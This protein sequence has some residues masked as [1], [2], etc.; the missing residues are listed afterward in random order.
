V[1]TP[2]LNVERARGFGS[3]ATV[4][5]GSR[6]GN[7]QSNRES[8]GEEDCKANSTYFFNFHCVVLREKDGLK[9]RRQ[10][11]PEPSV[12]QG[13]LNDGSALVRSL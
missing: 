3:K 10:S 13:D 11:T 7:D 5:R 8:A 2:V 4:L 1:A 6:L 9:G 12:S